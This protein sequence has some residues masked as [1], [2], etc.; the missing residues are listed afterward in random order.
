MGQEGEPDGDGEVKGVLPGAVA[1]PRV[2]VP[3]PEGPAPAVQGVGPLPQAQH[4]LPGREPDP[5]PPRPSR[6]L[7]VG[8]LPQ[9]PAL[10]VP[11]LQAL[12]PEGEG[13]AARAEEKGSVRPLEALGLQGG[14]LLGQG[15]GRQGL[16]GGP[17]EAEEVLPQEDRLQL[18]LGEA[19]PHPAGNGLEALRP[20]HPLP[21]GKGV[22]G[23]PAV[24]LP[25]VAD[26]EEEDAGAQ[27]GRHL[28]GAP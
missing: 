22:P 9:E 20:P 13:E 12:L 26:G 19:H 24:P 21:G 17:G 11:D 7:R 28:R 14:G 15:V 10:P 6:P 1:S 16:P 4:P 23:R 18:S 5:V 3:K 25:G 8:L 27:E 2:P